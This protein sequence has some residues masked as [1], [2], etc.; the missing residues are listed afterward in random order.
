MSLPESVAGLVRELHHVAIAVES[1]ERARTL[2]AGLIGLLGLV[3]SEVERVP[4]QRVKVFVLSAGGSRVEL[5]EPTAPD[6]PISKF[7]EKRGP[8]LHHLAYRVDDLDAALAALRR[9]SIRLID[10]TPRPGADGTRVAFLHP[11]ATGRVLIEL[12]EVPLAS[13]MRE[14]ERVP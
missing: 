13:A 12:V 8:G 11:K 1:I 6:S 14:L 10:E 5:V 3:E 7:L 4:D 9:Q 2:H